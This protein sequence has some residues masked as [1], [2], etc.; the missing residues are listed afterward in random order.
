MIIPVLYI[1]LVLFLQIIFLFA[2][3]FFFNCTL[4]IKKKKKKS[5]KKC[6]SKTKKIVKKKKNIGNVT[7]SNLF[8]SSSTP[9]TAPVS[10]RQASRRSHGTKFHGLCHTAQLIDALWGSLA[11]KITLGTAMP[12]SSPV[13]TAVIPLTPRAIRSCEQNETDLPGNFYPHSEQ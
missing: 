6:I 5:L 7:G 12:K 2:S 10:D 9:L 4:F 3:F 1:S 8:L 11:S 13:H